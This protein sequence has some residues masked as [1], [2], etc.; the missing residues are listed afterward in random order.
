MRV[1]NGDYTVSRMMTLP[2]LSAGSMSPLTEQSRSSSCSHPQPPF[3]MIILNFT[4][5][6]FFTETDGS[7]QMPKYRWER[8][9]V[10]D[11]VR[12]DTEG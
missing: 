2:T 5:D 10:G 4:V 12:G 1:R 6:G 3:H 9:E 8:S 7:S 11:K